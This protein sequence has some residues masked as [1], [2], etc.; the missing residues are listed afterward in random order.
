M[1]DEAEL[2]AVLGIWKRQGG[3]KQEGRL[4]DEEKLSGKWA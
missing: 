3:A 4:G 2:F 1:H